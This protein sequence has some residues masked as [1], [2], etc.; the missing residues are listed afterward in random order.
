MSSDKFTNISSKAVYELGR[1]VLRAAEMVDDYESLQY[2]TTTIT[3]D[4]S[5]EEDVYIA[6]QMHRDFMNAIINA[7][8][9]YDDSVLQP[10]LDSGERPSAELIPRPTPDESL[11]ELVRS[12]FNAGWYSPEAVASQIQAFFDAK[13]ENSGRR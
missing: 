4:G 5:Q 1:D 11:V 3:Y 13:E 12:L 8:E 9:R 6:S 2:E 7:L 10:T